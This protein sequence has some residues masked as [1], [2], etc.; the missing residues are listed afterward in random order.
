MMNTESR[1]KKKEAKRERNTNETN[2]QRH[3]DKMEQM[4]QVFQNWNKMEQ[5]ELLVLV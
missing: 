2:T 4:E 5:M 3:W 1:L